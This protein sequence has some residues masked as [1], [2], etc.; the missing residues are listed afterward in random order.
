MVTDTFPEQDI[1]HKTGYDY[2]ATSPSSKAFLSA[3]NLI[4]WHS[5]L[6]FL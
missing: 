2:R 6:L 4:Q 5:L 3:Q 1:L